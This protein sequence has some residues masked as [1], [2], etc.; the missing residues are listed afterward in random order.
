MT[1][2]S[3]EQVIAAACQAQEQGSLDQWL[4]GFLLQR[5]PD[6]WRSVL[7]VLDLDPA[8]LIAG[9]QAAIPIAEAQAVNPR[10]MAL[11]QWLVE[12]DPMD[13]P[14]LMTLLHLSA[15]RRD[16]WGVMVW[17]G[18][19][20]EAWQCGDPPA[21]FPV[22]PLW[23]HLLAT[24]QTE[25][26]LSLGEVLAER[27]PDA[28]VRSG[29][30]AVLAQLARRDHS[31]RLRAYAPHWQPLDLACP[32]AAALIKAL[33]NGSLAIALGILVTAREL[34]PD[35]SA[36][37]GLLANGIRYLSNAGH[38]VE[39]R[40]AIEEIMGQWQ[41]DRSLVTGREL[42]VAEQEEVAF[43][44]LFVLCYDWPYVED[45]PTQIR[46]I[47]Q[48]AAAKFSQFTQARYAVAVPLS[49]LPEAGSRV[50]RIGY[51]GSYF[52]RHSVGFLSHHTLA[53][54]DPA[55]VQTF[56]Y[57]LDPPDD[58]DD[59]YRQFRAQAGTFRDC[60]GWD[61]AQVTAQ[62]RADQLDVL[63]YMSGLEHRLGCEVVCLRAAPIQL[64]WLA[65]DSPGLPELDGFLVDPHLLSEQ[66]ATRYSEPLLRLPTF[67]AVSGFAVDPWDPV[68]LKQRLGIPLDWV[69]FWTAAPAKKRSL[70]S[71]RCQLEIVAQV[72]Q[73]VLVIKGSG[74]TQAVIN[75]FQQELRDPALAQRIRFLPRTASQEQHRGQLAVV[76]LILD[77]FPYVGST[78]TL[79]ALTLGIPVLTLAGEHYYTRQSYSL[80]MSVGLDACITWDPESY[81]S[82]GI[83]FGR[84]PAAL[85]SLKQQLKESY[86]HA[87]IWDPE[88]LARALEQQ[89]RQLVLDSKVR[90]W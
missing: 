8:V 38:L 60:H 36:R 45:N 78:H 74:D 30:L 57:H 82:Q 37:L 58:Q 73:S 43:I 15:S 11:R 90:S 53:A 54:H 35:D 41:L 51:L 65:G 48:A 70:E 80:L 14:N 72:P 5:D 13:R 52:R 20:I 44:V 33:N 71:I 88:G 46:G 69:V 47:Q 19:L 6:Q 66:A 64:S 55:Q 17:T 16:D 28:S 86:P 76:D 62:I 34:E 40:A 1:N 22:L 68:D 89:Y 12:L 75:L 32:T 25:A 67:T 50:L 39:M 9:V 87:P 59:I 77:T 10:S 4:R 85:Q 83:H 24:G 61:P 79:E 26:V 18:S 42:T 27:Q 56:C 23:D 7:E 29:I 2:P 3:L 84:D 49:P 81:V 31:E 21:L 63:V